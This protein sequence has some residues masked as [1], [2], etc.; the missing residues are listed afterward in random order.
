MGLKKLGEFGFIRRIRN[1]CVVRPAGVIQAIGDDAAAFKIPGNGATLVTTD[2]MVEGVHF[3]REAVTGEQLG[4]KAMAVN[5][6]D[7]AAMGG[8]PREAFVSLALP[9]G[10]S[11]DFMDGFYSGM[12]RLARQFQV[13]VLGGDTTRSLRDM[14]VNVAVVGIAAEGRILL[15]HNARP[16][17]QILVTGVLGDSAAGFHLIRNRIPAEARALKTLVRAHL[18]PV[19]HVAEGRF[20]AR[21]AGVRA[22]I[23]VSDGFA[24]DLMHIL[25]QSGVGACIE[26]RYLPISGA[27]LAFC[28]RFHRKALDFALNGG[29]DY[30][31]L[32]TAA[33]ESTDRLVEAFQKRFDRPLYRVGEVVH[34]SGI[35]LIG[36]DGVAE[37]LYPS[38]WDHFNAFD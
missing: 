16:G 8:T 4:H 9:E 18:T 26:A 33:R 32:V 14:V 3:L 17:D 12:T 24:S 15:R 30:V 7:I 1:G 20:L 28:S 29:E 23:D 19:P 21:Q 38:G 31:L 22:A 34:E 6:S 5:L 10:V 25:E 13:N 36:A 27:L 11:L 2:L 37:R 35:T